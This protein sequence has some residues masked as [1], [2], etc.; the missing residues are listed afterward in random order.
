MPG[1]NPPRSHEVGPA[2]SLTGSRDEHDP[3]VR[4]RELE[5]A[6]RNENKKLSLVQEVGR[7]LSSGL[8]LDR[9]LN[10]IMEKVT[11]LMEADRSTLYLVT[12]DG[13]ELWS[14]VLQGGESLEIRLAVGEGVAGWV[15]KSGEVLNIPDAYIDQRFQPRV[16]LESGYRTRSI[17]CVPLRDSHG[18]ILGVLQVLNKRGGPFTEEDE[19]LASALCGLAAIAIENSKLYHSVVGKNVELLEAQEKLQ[20]RTYEL[21]VLFEIEAEMSRALDIDELLER[22]L[23]RAIAMVGAGAGAIALREPESDV[24]RFCT[25]A[26]VLAE[27]LENTTLRIGQ[28]VLGT[29][30]AECRGVVVSSGSSAAQHLLCAPLVSGTALGAIQLFHEGGP[31]GHGFDDSDLR[32]LTLIAGQAAKAIRIARSRT[33]QA[34]QERLA[35]IGRMLAGVLHDLKTPMTIISGYAQLMAQIDEVEQ[36]EAYVEQILRQFDLMSGM[37]REVLAFAR[38]ETDVFIRKVYLHKFFEEVVTQLKHSLAGRQVALHLDIRY[39]G[40]AYLD[41]Q[42]ILRLIHN[43]ARNAADAMAA[44]GGGELRVT[45]SRADGQLR[46]S[47]AD[48]GPGIPQE[49]EGRL[50]ELFASG[51]EGGTGLGLAIVKKIVD[52]HRGTISYDST[53]GAGTTFHVALPLERPDN[54]IDTGEVPL[55]PR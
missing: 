29:A 5:A 36:R 45:A 10:L 18:A 20:Q 43:L 25:T 50:F 17:L 46:L 32:L 7:A 15:A 28:G 1:D 52:E 35:S 24:L 54:V 9:L 34:K 22:I 40:I 47:L 26:G 37:T 41:Q 53:P 49:M 30:V 4:L 3:L 39:D 8:D 21:N 33:E 14:K 38:G 31:Q 11:L 13:R 2:A 51:K 19:E 6:L 48:T 12:D 16:D 44:G 27:S 55:L 23:H 42:K